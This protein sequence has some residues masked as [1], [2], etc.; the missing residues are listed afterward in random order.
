MTW[1][2]DC[3]FMQGFIVQSTWIAKLLP[4]WNGTTKYAAKQ[5]IFTCHL[6]LV[7]FCQTKIFVGPYETLLVFWKMKWAIGHHDH[8]TKQARMFIAIVLFW[9]RIK[10]VNYYGI[11][12]N[13]PLESQIPLSLPVSLDQQCCNF[14][15][16]PSHP[17]WDFLI[18]QEYFS[19]NVSLLIDMELLLYHKWMHTLWLVNQLW[20]IVL[21]NPWKF[22]ISSELLY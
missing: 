20:F 12:Y 22:G 2:Q 8:I 19:P 1:L 18:K 16:S 5:V 14:A 17:G 10:E 13:R 11:N 3:R 15:P 9:S 6:P 4:S 21:V 7:K